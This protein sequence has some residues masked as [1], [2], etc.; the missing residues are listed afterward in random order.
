MI[1]TVIRVDIRIDYHLDPIIILLP[2]DAVVATP[3][4]AIILSRQHR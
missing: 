1:R 4:H 3:D 2:F